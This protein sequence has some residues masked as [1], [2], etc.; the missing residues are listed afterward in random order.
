M[1]ITDRD[2]VSHTEAARILGIAIMAGVRRGNLTTK[3]KAKVDAILD[4][5]EKRE[6]GK[7][8]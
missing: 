2:Y 5:A 6:R 3:Q 8:S 1:R 7:S 4:R